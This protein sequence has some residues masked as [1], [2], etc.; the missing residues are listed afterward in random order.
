MAKV[1][2][3][4]RGWRFDEDAVFDDDGWFRPLDE[5]PADARER[6]SRLAAIH[7]DPCDACWLVHGDEEIHRC[8]VA[9]VVYG[10]PYAEV[11]LC[12]DHEPD[13]TYWYETEGSEY[14][15]TAEFQD[16][17]HEWFAAGGRAPED[18]GAVEHVETDPDDVPDPDVDQAV[19]TVELPEEQRERYDLRTGEYYEGEAADRADGP[20]ES[21]DDEI[22]PADLD[23]L[24]REYPS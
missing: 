1:S 7:D 4:L 13:F 6:L 2:I 8:N 24:D 12:A 3:G 23:G 11:T 18:Y 9:E 16:R 10:E 22:D 5:M 15:G 17:F 20:D 21:E 14:R 19:R